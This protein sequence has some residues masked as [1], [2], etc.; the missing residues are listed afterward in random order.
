MLERLDREGAAA[1]LDATSP[2]SKRLYERYGFEAT[3]EYGPG[4]PSLW[5][6]WRES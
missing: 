4:G 6:M 2:D 1:S 3:G 5:S